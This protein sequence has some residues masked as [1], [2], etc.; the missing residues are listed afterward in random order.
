MHLLNRKPYW[1]AIIAQ[2]FY[3]GKGKSQEI[4]TWV[5]EN[6]QSSQC[7][8]I[9][10]G[11]AKVAR[12]PTPHSP[13]PTGHRHQRSALQ[14]FGPVIVPVLQ[15]Q[16]WTTTA[17]RMPGS[18]IQPPTASG[19]CYDAEDMSHDGTHKYHLLSWNQ[20]SPPPKRRAR[21]MNC[22]AIDYRMKE[23]RGPTPC[24]LMPVPPGA[25]V[26]PGYRR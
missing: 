18:C 11:V 4:N 12:V 13:M 20:K 24:S 15:E 3:Y 2:M 22:R 5:L 26:P 14:L 6:H 8:N 10:F 1:R 16:S 25:P 23:A 21:W 17:Q 9:N 7:N 19:S